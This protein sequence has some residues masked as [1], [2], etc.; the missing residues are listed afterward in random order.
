MF[1]QLRPLAL[2]ALLAPTTA[3]AEIKAPGTVALC[4]DLAMEVSAKPKGREQM[5]VTLRVTNTGPGDFQGKRGD[6]WVEHVVTV[7]GQ[8]V[9]RKKQGFTAIPSGGTK[10]FTFTRNKSD[11]DFGV[12]ALIQFKSPAAAGQNGDCNS[13]NNGAVT[14]VSF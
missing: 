6:A 8:E 7:A 14:P 10:D 1:V 11:G 13:A 12:W 2:V 4:A 3:L 5:T 9:E